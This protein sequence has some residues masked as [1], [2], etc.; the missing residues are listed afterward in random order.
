MSP[1]EEVVKMLLDEIERQDI[2]ALDNDEVVEMLLHKI[3]WDGINIDAL[4]NALLAR[5]RRL[6]RTEQ[7]EQQH[8][9]SR[10][11]KRPPIRFEPE[12]YTLEEKRKFFE[13]LRRQKSIG[14]RSRQ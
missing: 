6:E 2:D 14:H 3:Q 4:D 12:P 10:I 5:T 11:N 8:E 1:P 9:R 13:Q 7:H